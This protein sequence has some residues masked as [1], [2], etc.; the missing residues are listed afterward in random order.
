MFK[1]N[2]STKTKTGRTVVPY[3]VEGK[4][5]HCF[6]KNKQVVNL[7]LSDFD[8][9][10]KKVTPRIDPK[11]VVMVKGKSIERDESFGVFAPNEGGGLGG[12][13]SETVL[14][15]QPANEGT[16]PEP[17]PEIID[18]EVDTQAEIT[19]ARGSG[20]VKVIIPTVTL[21]EDF[22]IAINAAKIKITGNSNYSHSV[23]E[24][25]SYS[26]D[27]LYGGL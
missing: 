7:E 27:D 23:V 22:T 12:V 25:T 1:L 13:Y 18:I 24:A 21:G 15:T 4:V 14:A 20:E 10:K 9:K 26:Y 11:N 8:F 6:D 16:T 2:R 17:T 5:V 19:Y 3:L